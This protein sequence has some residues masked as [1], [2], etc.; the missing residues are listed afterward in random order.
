[1]SQ[2]KLYTLFGIY[3][4]SIMRTEVQ[5]RVLYT[6]VEPQDHRICCPNCRSKEVIRRGS[7]ERW[8]RSLPIGSRPTYIIAQ[9]PRVECRKCGVVRQIKLGFAA[10]RVRYTN[11]MERYVIELSRLMTIQ[12]V[13][14]H[15][16]LGWDTVKQII[17]GHLQRRYSRPSLKGL[18]HI[19]IDEICVGRGHKY[20]TI[21]L[22]LDTGAIVFVA[23]GKKA[24][25]LKPFWA[26]LRSNRVK[27]KAVAMD[28]SQAYRKAVEENLPGAA[29][30]FDRFHVIKLYNEK[31]SEL[32]RQLHRQATDD[33]H[34][35]VLKGTRWLLLKN[36]ENLDAT[37]GEPGRLREA[38]RLN[39]SLAIA[40]YLKDDLKQLWEQPDKQSARMKIYDWYHQALSS[41][42]GLVQQFAR[43]LLAHSHGILAWYDYSISNGPLE[44]TNN[45]IKTMNRIHYGLRDK[46][47]FRLKLYQLH[48]TKYALVG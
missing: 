31:L 32:R 35:Q 22:D 3:G 39:E 36:H 34:K 6:Y 44:G 26:R 16:G 29:I 37:K 45:K 4:Y 23:E 33:L 47:F 1:M 20:L 5:E 27:I 2:S 28:L 7:E 43:T 38:L 12:D 8:M 21:V 30:V 24:S 41:G 11:A 25:V 40:Y 15:T 10:P 19:G 17:K 13:A 46:E 14:Q 9:V 42:I 48:E 18:K